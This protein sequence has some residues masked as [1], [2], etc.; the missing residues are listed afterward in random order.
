MLQV[1]AD[2]DLL[3]WSR[4]D[5]ST[6][7]GIGVYIQAFVPTV[8]LL[9]GSLEHCRLG[10]SFELWHNV[11]RA[12]IPAL[13]TGMTLIVSAIIQQHTY[14]LSIFHAL[15]VLNLCWITVVT[16]CAPLYLAGVITALAAR[17]RSA[18]PPVMGAPIPTTFPQQTIRSLLTSS[19]IV[20]AMVAVII[21]LTLMG[22]FGV[23]VIRTI[24]TF[25]SAPDACTSSTVIWI[26]GYRSHVTSKLF[27]GGMF[28]LY[29]ELLVPICNLLPMLGLSALCTI[30]LILVTAPYSIIFLL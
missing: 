14:G 2:R 11:A 29:I 27:R 22:G 1:S 26:L 9:V 10:D 4:S 21:K 15:I 19:P 18:N 3:H 13:L 7:L 16:G 28:A 25:D 17:Q 12:V 30:A 24:N 23:W 6:R 20:P 8:S 5:V